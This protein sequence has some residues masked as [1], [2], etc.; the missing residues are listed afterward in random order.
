MLPAAAAVVLLLRGRRTDAAAP[1]IAVA[2]AVIDLGLAIVAAIARPSAEVTALN[3]IPGAV[4]VDGLAAIA[5]V[6]VAAV[7][8]AVV[9]FACGDIGRG[10]AR[11]RFFGTMLLFVAAMFVTV[12]AV[13]IFTLLAAW[14]IMGATSY[15][16]IGFWWSEPG[17]ARSGLIAFITT[18]SADVGMYVAAGAAL[19]AGAAGLNLARL[20]EVA[21]GWRDIALAGLALAALGKSAQLPFSFWL[22]HAMAGPSP[23]SALLHSAAMVAAGGYLL[24]RIE[25]GIT[26]T[27]WLGPVV[28]WI[29]ALTA[30][31]LGA[32]AVAQRDLKQL[33]AASTCSQ[34]GFI[35]LAAGVGGVAG[36]A[37]QFVAHAAVKSLLFLVAGAW[38]AALGT[39]NLLRLRGAA[40]TH[41]VAGITFTVGALALGGLPPL[42]IWV[43]KDQILSAALPASTALYTVGLA[44][45]AL[46]AAYSAKALAVIWTRPASVAPLD[47]RAGR[48]PVSELLPLPALAIAATVL[49]VL[50][51]PPLAAAWSRTLGTPDAP[52]SP[53]W[54]FA[55]SATLAVT[56]IVL[57]VWW[58]HR[59]LTRSDELVADTAWLRDWLKMEA[60][61]DV[62]VVRPIRALS[63]WCSR[64]DDRVLSQAVTT[65]GSAVLRLSRVVNARLEWAIAAAV[66][67]VA[68]GARRLATA[69]V[70]PQTG[71][72]HQYY[73]QAIV[74]MAVLVAV[75]ILMR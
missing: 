48:I 21:G 67:F 69:A 4:A 68:D 63:A 43:A 37:T 56:V 44:A 24:L 26:A 47:V 38:L 25:P 62:I 58:Q 7:F 13:N 10:E 40:R 3:S 23:V 36:G 46:S 9:V 15:A 61:I 66:A 70:R 65:V 30:L 1:A 2:V 32:V 34:I 39:K 72:L 41:P 20:D 17:K 5:M 14:E 42:S 57:V 8:L 16:L 50:G 74:G 35:V 33:L 18:R 22:S 52:T 60:G 75:F 31:L 11:S 51:V 27:G 28:A 73:D 19:A 6:T 53:P 59:R 54:E 45:A 64:F 12:T 55:M 49:G 71:L 29:G